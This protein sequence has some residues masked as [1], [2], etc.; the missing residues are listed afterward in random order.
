[1][2]GGRAA[3][4]V[5]ARIACA[6]PKPANRYGPTVAYRNSVNLGARRFFYKKYVYWLRPAAGDPAA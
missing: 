3:L 1:L 6:K 5:I 4:Q 2:L